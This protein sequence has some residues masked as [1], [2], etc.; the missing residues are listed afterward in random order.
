MESAIQIEN[1]RHCFG[2]KEVL[3]NINFSVGKG[4]I[5]GLLGPSGA[6]KTTLIN[7]LTGQLKAT[8]VTV[9]VM[10]VLSFLPMLSMFNDTIGK[11]SKILYS[12]QLYLL[13]NNLENMS[14]TAETGIIMT[15]NI[16]LI[17]VLFFMIYQKRFR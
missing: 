3:D 2:E 8:A 7:I 5:F 14:L 4:E 12:E 1:L 6:G 10:M 13:V 11:F 15:G 17:L 9:P 16:G